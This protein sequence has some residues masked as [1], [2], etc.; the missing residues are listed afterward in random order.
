MGTRQF[1]F[2]GAAA[3][4][5]LASSAFAADDMTGMV[6]RIDRLN[7]T[8]SIQ[9][10][11]GGTVGASGGGAVQEFKAKDAGMLE[12][13]HVGDRVSYSATEAG[14]TKTITKLQKAK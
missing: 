2:A 11:Q 9:Q 3:L 10:M 8:I 13:V 7:S 14:G 6:T 4:G 1:I 5:M 12:P